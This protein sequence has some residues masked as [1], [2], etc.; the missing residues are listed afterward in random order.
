MNIVYPFFEDG[1]KIGVGKC[2]FKTDVEYASV[3]FSQLVILNYVLTICN[4]FSI[5]SKDFPRDFSI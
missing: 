5:T 3:L 2:V 1:S 4:D